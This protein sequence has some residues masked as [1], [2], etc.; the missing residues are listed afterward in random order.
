VFF[1][2]QMVTFAIS[3]YQ[4]KVLFHLSSFGLEFQPGNTADL[5]SS[6]S[7]ISGM[8]RCLMMCSGDER[9]QTVDYDG[10][11]KMCR[12]FLTWANQSMFV[13]ST[14]L[15]RRIGFVE[16]TAEL[17]SFYQQPCVVFNDINRYLSCANNSLWSCQSGQFYDGSVCRNQY[18]SEM[19]TASYP[20]QCS[21]NQ[22]MHWNGTQCVPSK[23]WVH[24]CFHKSG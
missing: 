18:T 14:S 11:S 20:H 13:T 1:V 16:Q 21:D 4:Y 3:T 10:S 23:N 9:C 15:T 19:T 5:I 12:L 2:F 17:Y 24:L 6:Q 22:T 8:N 7:N